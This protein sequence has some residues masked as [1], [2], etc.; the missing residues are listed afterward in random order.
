[1][2][3]PAP[4]PPGTWVGDY[5]IVRRLATGGFGIVYLAE[6]AAKKQVA[7][8]EYLP[9]SLAQRGPGEL[10]PKVDPDKLPLYRLG[11]KSFFEEARALAQITHPGV[12]SV[13]NFL[14]ENDTV[15]MVMNYLQGDTLQEFIVAAREVK[16]ARVLRE[17]TIRSLCEE[18]LAG[19]A[20][21]HE[22]GMLHLDIKPANVFITD[23][24]RAVL[25]DFGA[26]REVFNQEANFVRPMYT[27][28]FAAPEMYQRGALLGPWTDLYALGA[29]IYA[30][31]QGYPP[32]DVPQRL[33]RDRLDQSLSRLREV[34]SENLLNITRWCMALDPLARPQNV[35]ELQQALR[36]KPA[37][38]G[39][40]SCPRSELST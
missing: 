5:Q 19:L 20:S 37:P 21:V 8:K 13:L 32:S 40:K 11:Q 36:Q 30:C 27:P 29:C 33:D 39:I 31:M 35:A 3:K 34:Y 16:G 18:I 6:D 14:R 22:H 25:L 23:D 15:Y 24:N 17:A 28:G 1:M 10:T 26:A 12:V 38:S 2:S 7:L 4:L 9:A